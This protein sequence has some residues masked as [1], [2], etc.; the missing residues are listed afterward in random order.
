MIWIIEQMFGNLGKD[1]L[2]GFYSRILELNAQCPEGTV[3]GLPAFQE[4]GAPRTVLAQLRS[5]K[6]VFHL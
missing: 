2:L 3:V 5:T 6:R 4:M 1:Y